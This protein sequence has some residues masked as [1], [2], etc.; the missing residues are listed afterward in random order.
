MFEHREHLVEGFTKR[1]KVTKLVYYELHSDVREA[2]SREKQ[3]KA[4]TRKKKEELIVRLN[5]T[6]D[7][8]YQTIL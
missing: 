2:I 4:G 6:W 8:L 5:P 7:D 3:L 1:Y